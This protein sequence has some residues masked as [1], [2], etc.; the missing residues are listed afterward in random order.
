LLTGGAASI[1]FLAQTTEIMLIT[2]SGNVGI[3]TTAPTYSLQIL[4]DNTGAYPGDN[5]TG[6]LVI[7]GATDSTKKF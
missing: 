1:N 3:G 5:T 6:E 7:S 4:Q 2:S